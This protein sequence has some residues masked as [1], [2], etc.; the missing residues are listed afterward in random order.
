L[1]RHEAGSV[2]VIPVILRDV[3]WHPARFGKL[4]PLPKDGEPVMLWPD[5]DTAW[6]DV[7]HGIR[8]AAEACRQ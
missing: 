4:Q 2:R 5:K 6:K 7:A 8:K 3:D 1:E